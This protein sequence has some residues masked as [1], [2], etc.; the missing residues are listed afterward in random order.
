MLLCILAP[1]PPPAL[2]SRPRCVLPGS[3]RG[4]TPF[5]VGH[6]H[7]RCW[8][9]SWVL[10]WP[11]QRQADLCASPSSAPVTLVHLDISKS[12]LMPPSPVPLPSGTRLRSASPCL[13]SRPVQPHCSHVSYGHHPVTVRCLLSSCCGQSLFQR[14]GLTRPHP[15][16]AENS[17]GSVHMVPPTHLSIPNRALFLSEVPWFGQG[18]L[19]S[20][21]SRLRA[22]ILSCSGLSAL[23]LGPSTGAPLGSSR[24]PHQA[25]PACRSPPPLSLLSPL[26]SCP[27]L[28]SRPSQSSPGSSHPVTRCHL[29]ATW[30]VAPGE[31]QLSFP[32]CLRLPPSLR[33]VL[34]AKQCSSVP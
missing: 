11:G 13:L 3:P 6:V 27:L 29:P 30:H 33:L 31:R 17:Q 20:P 5:L 32:F 7:G 1:A 23:S 16:L 28:P 25:L 12:A 2:S 22:S 34:E 15:P 21:S 18:T 24:A 14:T 8:H 10:R 26:L 9:T 4:L 19:R